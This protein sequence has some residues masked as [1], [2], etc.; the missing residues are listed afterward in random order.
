[1]ASREATLNVNLAASDGTQ[2]GF[3][4]S[5]NQVTADVACIQAGSYPMA[6]LLYLNSIHGFESLPTGD[7]E[8]ELAHCFS[9]RAT[10]ASALSSVAG[11]NA[12]V[13][14]TGFVPI[15]PFCVDFRESGCSPPIS[16]DTNACANNAGLGIAP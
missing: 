11:Q 4:L 8:L 1:V 15:D 14:A 6:R 13:A 3:D 7:Q 12:L 2:F 5:L 9:G 16:P 10:G